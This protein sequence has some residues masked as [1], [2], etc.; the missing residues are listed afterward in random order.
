MPVKGARPHLLY[1][2]WGFP[3]CRSGGV[4]RALATANAF[5]RDGWDVTVLTIERDLWERR[6]GAD[7]A[8]EERVDPRIRVE[9]IPFS[10]PVL[11][12]DLSLWP[13]LRVLAP[14]AWVKARTTLDQ[15]TFPEKV[16]GPWR[17]HLEG[18]AERIHAEHP[19]DL[20]VA[21]TNPQVAIT[22]A[23]RL[24]ER[25]DV[26]YV[27]DYRDA[28]SLDVFSGRRL[29]PEGSRVNRWEQ[30]ALE[31]A[32]EVWFVNE[33]IVQWHRTTYPAAAAHMHVVANGFDEPAAG[34]GGR[35]AN[36]P[37]RFTYVGTISGKVPIPE[38]VAGWRRARGQ[39]PLLLDAVADLY[40]YLGYYGA[41]HPELADALSTSAE[42]G[43]RFRGPVSK[44]LVSELYEASDALLLVLGTGRYV[45][46]GKVFEYLATGLP[47]ISVHDPG[48]AASEVLKGYPLWFP[49]SDLSPDGVAAAL[50][51]GA[52]AAA[53][54]EPAAQAAARAFAER[55]SREY[56]LRP[57]ITALRAAVGASMDTV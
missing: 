53:S 45:T 42:V 25:Y 40:G 39:E 5:A 22:A 55:Y 10:W 31:G 3:P 24:A 6:T 20:V 54:L 1:V 32:Q 49:A 19:V 8:L 36:A 34:S 46:S 29:Y 14:R 21:T 23:L 17:R 4:Y 37:L 43:V 13:A 15:L 30:R 47:I 48:N 12:D 38:L 35:R 41:A 2:A 16:Y 7:P 27:V 56:Q 26:P 50:R 11:E 9:R 57:R 18:A 28:W 52:R 51:D 44:T 33:P